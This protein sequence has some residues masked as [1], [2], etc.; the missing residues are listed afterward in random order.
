MVFLYIH[1]Y[2]YI[3]MEEIGGSRNMKSRGQT[4]KIN[5]SHQ[6]RNK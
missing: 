1:T 3:G 5:K 6:T 4:K 2:L